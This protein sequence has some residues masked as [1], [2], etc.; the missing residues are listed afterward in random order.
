METS[1]ATKSEQRKASITFAENPYTI[2]NKDGRNLLADP[3]IMTDP[4][5]PL[6]DSPGMTFTFRVSFK[7]QRFILSAFNLQ[8]QFNKHNQILKRV[9]VEQKCM[10]SWLTFME[11]MVC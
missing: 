4:E 9:S 3:V 1:D 5:W 6:A 8:I 2:V 7:F 10:E 11:T